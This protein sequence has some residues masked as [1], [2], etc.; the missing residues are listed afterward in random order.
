MKR[1]IPLF[2]LMA[3]AYAA[4]ASTCAFRIVTGH[5][6]IFCGMTHAMLH[7]GNPGWILG[8]AVVG[9]YAIK[10]SAPS[11]VVIAMVALASVVR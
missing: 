4:D 10:R 8:V 2:A 7:G 9:C 11:W 3:V 5:P 1:F 6:C